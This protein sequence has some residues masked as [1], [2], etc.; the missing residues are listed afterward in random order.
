MGFSGGTT[1]PPAGTKFRRGDSNADG[2]TNIAEAVFT[3]SYL[4]ASG[5]TPLCSDATDAN[6]DGALDIADAVAVLG[7]LF[8]AAGPLPEPFSACGEEAAEDTSLG[9]EAFP[10]CSGK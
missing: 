2:T 4:F 8:A 7:H 5:V 6:N 1:A 10:A 3:L 9:C